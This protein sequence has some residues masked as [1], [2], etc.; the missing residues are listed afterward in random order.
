MAETTRHN[1]QMEEMKLKEIES[2]KTNSDQKKSEHDERLRQLQEQQMEFAHRLSLVDAYEKI[3][4][5]LS[6][7]TIRKKFPELVDFIESDSDS[8]E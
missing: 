4:G 3:K 1:K 2:K 6:K 5:R 8:G 7:A